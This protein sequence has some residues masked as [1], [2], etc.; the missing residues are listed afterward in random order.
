M[1]FVH[2][3]VCRNNYWVTLGKW[4]DPQAVSAD[5]DVRVAGDFSLTTMRSTLL[6]AARTKADIGAETQERYVIFRTKGGRQNYNIANKDIV[7]VPGNF[8]IVSTEA[9]WRSSASAGFEFDQL[10]FPAA[11]MKPLLAAGRLQGAFFLAPDS[12]FG[13]LLTSAMDAAI[14]QF[15]ALPERT[16]EAVLR[17][18][19]GLAAL[20]GGASEEGLRVGREA[21]RARRLAEAK[22]L[23]E[24]WL[25]RPDLAADRIAAKL[26]ISPRALHALFEPTGESF[27]AYV[28][29]RRLE[30]C[31]AALRSPG[32]EH[33]KIADI[34]FAWGFGS[35]AT[36]NRVFREAYGVAPSEA[37]APSPSEV[38]RRNHVHGS[39]ARELD[40]VSD[41]CADDAAGLGAKRDDRPSGS[42]MRARDRVLS[43][44]DRLDCTK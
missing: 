38:A 9:G 41:R 12:P 11:A 43:S 26:R 20:A 19:C 6:D 25:A 36:F 44:R 32:A 18:I 31:D 22:S 17:N 37:R 10:L 24:R 33:R 40:L 21:L 23:I 29:R 34:A 15:D 7:F 8:C 42:P 30:R 28:Q 4:R 5:F 2:D 27:G 39:R 1:Q 35:L 16:M 3:E 14:S 13:A